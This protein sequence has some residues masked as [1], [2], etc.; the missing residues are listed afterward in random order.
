MQSKTRSDVIL[1][2]ALVALLIAIDVAARV[3]PHVPG[4][5]PVAA[6]A[7]ASPSAARC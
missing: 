1:D 7:S 6:S 2:L 5:W 4:V 3:M